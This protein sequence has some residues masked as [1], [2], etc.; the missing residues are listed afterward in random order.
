MKTFTVNTSTPYEVIIE[1]ALLEHIDERVKLYYSGKKIAIIVDKNIDKYYAKD[2]KKRLSDFE[3]KLIP[4]GYK[5]E[6]DA[7]L[8]NNI[9]KLYKQFFDFKLQ[10]NDL[11]I[12][13]G[14]GIVC[15]AAGFAATTYLGGVKFIQIPASLSAQVDLAISSNI[16]IDTKESA[17]SIRLPFCPTAVFVDTDLVHTISDID[18]A[19]GMATLIKY[20]CIGDYNL[21]GM[22]R[23]LYSRPKAEEFI[24]EIV[25]AAC[26]VKSNILEQAKHDSKKEILLS[27]G[28]PLARAI[29]NYFENKTITYTKS[30]HQYNNDSGYSFG[31]A[32]L[33]SM[34]YTAKYGEKIGV[35]EEGTAELLRKIAATQELPH[36]IF[37]EE[38]EK[39]FF[40]HIGKEWIGF[41]L[42][43]EI[44]LGIIDIRQ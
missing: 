23:S 42:L 36:R 32:H 4:V 6:K 5:N 3:L 41:V 9:P 7:K 34:Y 20:G 38:K 17:R 8:F 18:F 21:F 16:H 1:K 15:D 25:Y 2:M 29:K 33:I 24:Q 26:M 28:I 27:F 31:E 14:G 35:S 40:E 43:K 11:V 12:V 22:I 30:H 13:I 10:K 39:E 37:P 44:G 19:S